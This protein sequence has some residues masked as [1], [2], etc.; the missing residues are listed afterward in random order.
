MYIDTNIYMN[1]Y[2]HMHILTENIL[3][4]QQGYIRLTDF[5]F[6][7]I[8]DSH[9]NNKNTDANTSNNNSYNNNQYKNVLNKD[10]TWTLCGTP[11]YVA[12]EIIKSKGYGYSVDWWSLGVLLYELSTGSVPFSE[13]QPMLLYER[14]LTEG[15]KK[16]SI[17]HKNNFIIYIPLQLIKT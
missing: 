16:K 2:I 12:P 1:T 9:F 17:I 3:L 7:K 4:D 5:G 15:K 11:E 14:I 10:K 13:E 6:A 8:L